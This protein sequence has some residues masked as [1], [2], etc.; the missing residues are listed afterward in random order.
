MRIIIETAGY[1]MDNSTPHLEG[2]KKYVSGIR[3]QDVLLF[4]AGYY[5]SVWL[6]ERAYGSLSVS[7]PF[8]LPGAVLLS[9]FLLTQK[10][11]W[12]LIA[13]AVFPIRMLAGA[14]PGTPFW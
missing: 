1:L 9:S 4:C 11:Y 12:P 3:L 5:F 10:K 13:V 2:W 8:W 7:S 14:P 6:G